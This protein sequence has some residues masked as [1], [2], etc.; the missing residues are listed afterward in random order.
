LPQGTYRFWFQR[1]Y[2]PKEIRRIVD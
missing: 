2:S 1:E